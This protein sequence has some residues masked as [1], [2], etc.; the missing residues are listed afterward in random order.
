MTL[1]IKGLQITE[2]EVKEVT[3]TGIYV[4]VR[5][6]VMD[7]YGFLRLGLWLE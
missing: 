1:V 2:M 4:R 3:A 7:F 5:Q 6:W